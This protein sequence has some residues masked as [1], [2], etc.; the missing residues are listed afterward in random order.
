MENRNILLVDDDSSF[1]RVIKYHVENAGFTAITATSGID[2]L[3]IHRERKSA[4][5]FT[6][7]G[8]AKMSGIQFITAIREFD[9]EVSI[10]VISGLGSIDDAVESM[11]LGAIDFIKKP[12]EQSLFLTVLSKAY[13]IYNLSRENRQLK[14][15]V[16]NNLSFG[17]MI[18]KSDKME[19]LYREASRVA[20]SN[21]TVLINGETGAGK[22]VLTKAIH[23]NSQRK[24]NRFIALN[25]AA[26]PSNL[27]E[28]E[29]FGHVK[30]AFTGATTNRKGVLEEADNG[31]F[32]MD[33]IGDLPLELQPKLLRIIQEREFQPVGSNKIIKVNIRFICATHRNL[34]E[35]VSNG[36]FREDLF[37][38][39]NVLP[40]YI[41][42]V[43]KRKEDILPLFNH[44]LSKACTAENRDTPA[45]SKDSALMLENYNWPG[46]VREIQ[47]IA[48][49]CAVLSGEEISIDDLPIDNINPRNTIIDK[50]KDLPYDLENHIDNLYINALNLNTWNQSKTAKFLNISRNSVVYRLKREALIEAKKSLM[51]IIYCK[52]RGTKLPATHRRIRLPLLPSGPGGVH[53]LPLCGT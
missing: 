1:L 52:K 2:A 6:D 27:I 31:T 20:P 7:M 50:D 39:L 30:G 11:K 3:K 47:N 51:I 38:R 35:M 10:V 28:S 12:I 36:S 45:I 26:I 8:M 43:R 5:I 4:V 23:I 18:G 15:L 42:P 33:E 9:T 37:F 21:A 48:L 24:D 14:E 17:N 13:N 32:F 16:T 41:P 34:K 40:L 46:N 25:C 49:R 19:Q 29:L 44:F 22:E 53:R